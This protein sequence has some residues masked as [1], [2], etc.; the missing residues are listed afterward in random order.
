[1]AGCETVLIQSHPQS[2]RQIHG[3]LADLKTDGKHNNVEYLFMNDP[4]F[5][6]IA[7][8][9]VIRTR[10]RIDGMYPRSDKSN[11][12]FIPGPIVIFL[13]V[14]SEGSHVHIKDGRI[15]TLFAVVF[16]YDRLFHRIHTAHGRTVPV[17]ATVVVSRSHTLEPGDLLGFFFIG[18]PHQMT[19]GG[20]RCAQDALELQTGHDIG[21]TLVVVQSL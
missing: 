18:L 3:F 7:E 5:I 6:G 20:A 4:V 13:V 12:M 14:L 21:V 16:G 17:S 10:N 15:Q 1:M 2:S 11:P 8:L 19:H 9:K